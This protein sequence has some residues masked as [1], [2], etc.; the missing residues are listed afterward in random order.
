MSRPKINV[1]GRLPVGSY[2]KRELHR[3]LVQD[4]VK[5]H[6]TE[7]RWFTEALIRIGGGTGAG[8]EAAMIELLDDV[9]TATG[10]RWLPQASA[11]PADIGRML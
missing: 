9:E 3:M 4:A 8:A 5:H 2:T 7:L 6:A 1:D 10:R 11:T